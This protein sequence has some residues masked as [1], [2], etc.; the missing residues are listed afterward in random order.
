MHFIAFLRVSDN[1]KEFWS[2]FVAKGDGRGLGGGVLGDGQA[3]GRRP[4]GL[5]A[6]QC[7]AL[8]S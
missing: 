1:F 8:Q 6:I 2:G 5:G 7:V 4:R 3:L